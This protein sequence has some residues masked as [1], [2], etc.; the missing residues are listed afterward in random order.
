MGQASY[1][2]YRN[3]AGARANVASDTEDAVHRLKQKAEDVA[4]KVSAEGAKAL[5]NAGETVEDAVTATKRFVQDQ[6]L[7]ALGAVAAFACAVGALW[8]MSPARRNDDL[9]QRLSDYVEPG[10]RALKRRI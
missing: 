2:P 3:T 9:L 1:D 6:P 4:D 5:K 7:L 8:K 10:Y